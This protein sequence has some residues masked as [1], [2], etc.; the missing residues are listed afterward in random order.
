[1]TY[2]HEAARDLVGR[3]GGGPV[4]RRRFG[5]LVSADPH[6]ARW[7]DRVPLET[8]P[9]LRIL[10]GFERIRQQVIGFLS[11]WS[12]TI[13]TRDT[14]IALFNDGW[15]STPKDLLDTACQLE[16]VKPLRAVRPRK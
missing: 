9:S 16:G 4:G 5:Q 10:R 15:D 3:E 13:Q 12:P 8:V 6:L 1:M 14:A 7:Y 11:Y 2:A